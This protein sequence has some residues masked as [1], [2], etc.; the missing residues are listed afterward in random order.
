VAGFAVL[1]G[2]LEDGHVAG[3]VA[4]LHEHVRADV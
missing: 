1:G 4:L 3:G 2:T